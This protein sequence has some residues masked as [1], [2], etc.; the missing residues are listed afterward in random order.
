MCS[1]ITFL[2]RISQKKKREGAEQ[3]IS[4]Y[5]NKVTKR[6]KETSNPRVKI[7][8]KGIEAGKL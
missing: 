1:L 4:S 6:E 8:T 2:T 5:T 3:P 7:K